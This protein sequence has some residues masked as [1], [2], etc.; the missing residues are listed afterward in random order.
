M[1][2]LKILRTTSFSLFFLLSGYTLVHAQAPPAS[3]EAPSRLSM[4]VHDL[5]TWLDRIGDTGAKHSRV[6]SHSP[7]L[8][9]PRQAERAS[10]AVASNKK[11]PTP[12]QIR[13]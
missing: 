7:P 13:D 4:F 5:T 8:P 3:T 9:R 6:V 11:T 12:V 1:M 2:K 10:A